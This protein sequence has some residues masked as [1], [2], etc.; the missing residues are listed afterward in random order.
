MTMSVYSHVWMHS[1][2]VSLYDTIMLNMHTQTK[3]VLSLATC[4][5]L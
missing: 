2:N 3:D 1:Y 5:D 4:L